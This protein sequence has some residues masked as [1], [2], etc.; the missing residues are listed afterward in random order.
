MKFRNPAREGRERGGVQAAVHGDCSSLANGS[1]ATS[2]SCSRSRG[3]A[4][5]E[6]ASAPRA[7]PFLRSSRGSRRQ[8]RRRR[9]RSS[10]QIAI[11][12]IDPAAGEHQ[13][14]GGERHAFR[15]ARP[16]AVRADRR[17]GREPGSAS[18]QGSPH[19]SLRHLGAAG[20]RKSRPAVAGGS[21]LCSCR[22]LHAADVLLLLVSRVGRVVAPHCSLLS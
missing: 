21:I 20:Q 3:C 9:P 5:P 4:D 11:G 14:S 8:L 19:R 12:L 10:R 17:Y 2:S 15:R 16:S 7:P 1:S 6:S 13:R 18:R 22:G